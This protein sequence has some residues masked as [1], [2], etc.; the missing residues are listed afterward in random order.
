MAIF[1][2]LI[3][4]SIYNTIATEI[5]INCIID[6]KD[7]KLGFRILSKKRTLQKSMKKII[8]ALIIVNFFYLDNSLGIERI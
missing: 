1:F 3:S 6:I 7:N 8:I 4:D 2:L 5:N